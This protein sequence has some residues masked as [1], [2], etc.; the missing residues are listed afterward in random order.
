MMK[1]DRIPE[2]IHISKKQSKHRSHWTE[3]I[4]WL[5]NSILQK[6][7]ELK[8]KEPERVEICKRQQSQ[9]ML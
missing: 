7:P 3:P 5:L 9:S 2:Y 8:R 6:N 1:A 4:E